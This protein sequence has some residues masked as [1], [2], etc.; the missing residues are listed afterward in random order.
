MIHCIGNSHVNTFSNSSIINYKTFDNPYF[1]PH[2]IGPTIAYNFFEHHLLKALETVDKIDKQKDFITLIVGEVDCRYHLPK[3]AEE[4]KRSDEDIV[5]ECIDRFIRCY[6]E[7]KNNGYKIIITGTHPTTTAEHDLNPH[8]PIWGNVERRNKICVLWN[9]YLKS[10]AK[11]RNVP[12]ISIYDYLVD[13]N[14]ITKMEYYF[15]N[16]HLI[17]NKVYDFILKEMKE[18][19]IIIND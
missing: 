14:N 5:K 15:D 16:N 4:Q 18:A 9:R 13:E 1:I 12:F 8:G 7:F 3:Q 11:K 2:W 19:G 17:G 10:E 6:D